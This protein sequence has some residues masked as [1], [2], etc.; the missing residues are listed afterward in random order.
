M[1]ESVSHKGRFSVTLY[2]PFSVYGPRT[3]FA[4]DHEEALRLVRKMCGRF[5]ETESC[6]PRVDEVSR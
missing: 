6:G 5:E 3:V 4:R 1:A 2:F